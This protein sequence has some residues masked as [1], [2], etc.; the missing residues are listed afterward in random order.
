MVQNLTAL[1]LLSSYWFRVSLHSVFCA[2]NLKQLKSRM[3]KIY[4]LNT[5]NIVSS[6]FQPH[7]R[8]FNNNT[9]KN[10]CATDFD[11]YVS[12]FLTVKLKWWS[13]LRSKDQI[14]N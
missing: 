11:A 3:T 8:D 12:L 10:A 6:Q 4:R 1:R 2:L 7:N 14:E 9:R 5:C 13:K